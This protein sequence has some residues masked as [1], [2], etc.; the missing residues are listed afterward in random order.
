MLVKRNTHSTKVITRSV[1][2][3]RT[4]QG[5][6]RNT[7]E[8]VDIKNPWHCKLDGWVAVAHSPLGQLA[9]LLIGCLDGCWWLVGILVGWLAD[10]LGQR[11]PFLIFV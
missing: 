7:N 11:T 2:G 9:R 10:K 1:M 8:I 6:N 4:P 3:T 5:Y